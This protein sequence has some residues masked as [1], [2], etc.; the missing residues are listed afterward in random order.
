[1]QFL[2]KR[3]FP[4]NRTKLVRTGEKR[5]HIGSI[6]SSC[7]SFNDLDPF[8]GL[9][10]DQDCGTA[11][12]QLI[13]FLCLPLNQQHQVPL[14][15]PREQSHVPRPDHNIYH[16]S[17]CWCNRSGSVP[18]AAFKNPCIVIGKR[19][20]CEGERTGPFSLVDKSEGFSHRR[21]RFCT[22]PSMPTGQRGSD[23]Q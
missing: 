18:K 10:S 15:D 22:S 7:H 2:P 1:M 17:A 3:L 4:D 6:H 12:N 23:V 9:W 21:D 19:E 16:F 11:T 14:H 5:V 13:H 8:L 20:V